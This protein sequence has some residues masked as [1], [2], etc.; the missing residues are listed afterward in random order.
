MT[1]M[2]NYINIV[3]KQLINEMILPNGVTYDDAWSMIKADPSY[4]AKIHDPDQDLQFA[5]VDADSTSIRFIKHPTKDTQLRAVNRNGHSIKFIIDMGIE[6]DADVRLDAVIKSGLAIKWI[7]NPTRTEIVYAM[8]GY[9]AATL[10]YLV[11]NKIEI[12]LDL[13]DAAF[14]Y[15]PKHVIDECITDLG[16]AHIILPDHVLK[17]A[18]NAHPHLLDTIIRVYGVPSD[19]IQLAAVESDR[20]DRYP[21][22]TLLRHGIIP[23]ETVQRAAVVRFNDNIGSLLLAGIVPSEDITNLVFRKNGKYFT[24]FLHAGIIPSTP[25]QM[26]SLSDNAD[27]ALLNFRFMILMK[28]AHKQH[29]KIDDAVIEIAVGRDAKN[30]EHVPHPSEHLQMMAVNI[31]PKTI[32][33]IHHPTWHVLDHVARN[34]GPD[35]LKGVQSPDA[36]IQTMINFI[37]AH[38]S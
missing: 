37:L 28:T 19:D 14:E 8:S 3:T 1:H 9:M 15:K 33:L 18:L 13:V 27:V 6:P 20:S 38:Q 17:T 36:H 2:R 32:K 25:I 7:K 29:V 35:L 26:L 10:R 30:I 4:I 34:H 22:T 16:N 21:I 24:D 12:P 5:A 11:D 23:S 31:D